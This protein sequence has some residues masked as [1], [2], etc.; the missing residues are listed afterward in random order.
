ML[1][2]GAFSF[3]FVEIHRNLEGKVLQLQKEAQKLVTILKKYLKLYTRLHGDFHVIFSD[4]Q[5]LSD[6]FISSAAKDTNFERM[7][8][9][10]MFC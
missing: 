4:C 5:L 7:L 8:L 10:F 6:S 9:N 2:A 1:W 3:I